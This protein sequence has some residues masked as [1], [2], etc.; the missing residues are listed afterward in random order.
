M[1][2]LYLYYPRSLA[3]NEN[4]AYFRDNMIKLDDDFEIELRLGLDEPDDQNSLAKLVA[5]KLNT[6][7][8]ELP[9]LEVKKKSIDA[10]HGRVEFFITMGLPDI[11]ASGFA[12]LRPKRLL[13][14]L[15][16]LLEPGPQV[17]FVPMS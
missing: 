9:V 13:E 17:F 12:G 10:R 14:S 15:W 2:G 5:K 3:L 4:R 1:I 7:V 6:Q 8:E 11:K 16:S